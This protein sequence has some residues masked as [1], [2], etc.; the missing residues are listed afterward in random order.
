MDPANDNSP[1]GD[2]LLG[3]RAVATFLGI[4]QRQIYRLADERLIPTFKVGGT[5][6]ARRSSLTAWMTAQEAATRAA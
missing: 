2:M 4:S 3:A 6:S 1:V 5:L